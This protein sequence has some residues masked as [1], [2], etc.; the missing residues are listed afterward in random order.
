M[1]IKILVLGMGGV[2]ILR[3]KFKFYVKKSITEKDYSDLL[4]RTFGT[5][6]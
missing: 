5:D 4:T 6:Y 3:N 2:N 1:L